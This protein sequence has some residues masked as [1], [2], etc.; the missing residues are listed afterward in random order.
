M[1]DLPRVLIADAQPTV[2]TRVARIMEADGFS[3]CAEANDAADALEAA[4]RERPDICVL[5]L[6]MEG[7]SLEAIARISQEM[8]DTPVVVLTVSTKLEDLIAAVRAG[9]SGYLLKEMNPE[10][11][12]DAARGVL[13]GEAAIPRTLVRGLLRELQLQREG[14]LLKGPN[15]SVELTPREWQILNLMGDRLSTAEIAAQLFVSPITV[16][17]HISKLIAKL[18]VSTREGAVELL[19]G[20]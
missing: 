6:Q 4:R 18:G 11:I 17:R 12:P 20:G 16:R 5:G 2:R 15:G 14:R 19:D 10:R 13:D 1:S 9:A 3:V 7:S 8:P